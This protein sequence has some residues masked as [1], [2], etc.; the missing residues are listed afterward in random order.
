MLRRW[1]RARRDRREHVLRDARDLLTSRATAPTERRAPEP[2]STGEGDGEGDRH[3]RKV[4]VE[5]ARVTGYVIGQK[6]AD[7]CSAAL[8]LT[9]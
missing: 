7:L 6:A 3:W 9:G 1:L 5:I 2:A 8:E 4:A